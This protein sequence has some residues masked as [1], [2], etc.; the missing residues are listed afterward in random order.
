MVSPTIEI[1]DKSSIYIGIEAMLQ[2][3]IVDKFKP[4]QTRASLGYIRHVRDD[5][6]I[7][8]G[9]VLIIDD[10]NIAHSIRL[11]LDLF[12]KD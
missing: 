5:M 10:I 12:Y 4:N 1:N 8:I 3:S 7:R 9:Y 6:D 2:C 11:T